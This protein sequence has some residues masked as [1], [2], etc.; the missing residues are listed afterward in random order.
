MVFPYSEFS[1]TVT[2]EALKA[3]PYRV[4]LALTIRMKINSAGTSNLFVWRGIL[5]CA[6]SISIIFLK[7]VHS[8][9]VKIYCAWKNVL[10]KVQLYSTVH[11]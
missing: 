1:V 11:R 6:G 3:A 4:L 8:Y 2:L 7:D 9:I 5:F 10:I